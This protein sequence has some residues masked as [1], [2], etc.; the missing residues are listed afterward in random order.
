MFTLQ[1]IRFPTDRIKTIFISTLLK[2][3]ALVWFKSQRQRDETFL[4]N[5]ELFWTSFESRFGLSLLEEEQESR[6]LN[7]SLRRNESID[8]FHTRFMYL[9]TIVNYED[10]PL[11]G[12]YL[13]ALNHEL[14]DH[15]F[16]LDC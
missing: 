3:S 11:R 9:A 7:I 5:L 13:K 15:F 16:H 8:E 10:R 2:D 4:D 12:I 14:L 6:L 1:P